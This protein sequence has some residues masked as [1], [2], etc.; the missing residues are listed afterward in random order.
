MQLTRW[1]ARARRP[2]AAL[3]PADQVSAP[4]ASWEEGLCKARATSLTEGGDGV[5]AGR[6]VRREE[7]GGDAGEERHTDSEKQAPQ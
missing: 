3:A 4:A 5:D 7:S 1:R 2:E 6:E